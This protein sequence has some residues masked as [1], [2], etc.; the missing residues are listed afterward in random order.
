MERLWDFAISRRNS[1]CEMMDL[2]GVIVVFGR[3]PPL[4]LKPPPLYISLRRVGKY[5]RGLGERRPV[6]RRFAGKGA[7]SLSLPAPAS[8]SEW[9]AVIFSSA[10]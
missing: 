7:A 3:N 10:G 4:E 5:P 2:P 8:P 1:F 9:G 6:A